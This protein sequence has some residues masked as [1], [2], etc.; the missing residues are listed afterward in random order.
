MKYII[1]LE[2]WTERDD[3]AP[4]PAQTAPVWMALDLMD[5][6]L[7]QMARMTQSF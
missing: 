5:P 1:L 3:L 2:P 6:A 4:A 7:A